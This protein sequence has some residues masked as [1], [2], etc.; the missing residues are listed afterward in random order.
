VKEIWRVSIQISL[1]YLSRLYTLASTHTY[2]AATGIFSITLKI[3][4]VTQKVERSKQYVVYGSVT[5]SKLFKRFS[6][7]CYDIHG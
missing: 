2:D 1:L 4:W 3:D 7:K 5:F 6:N